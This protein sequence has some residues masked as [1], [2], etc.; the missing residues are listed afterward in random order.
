MGYVKLKQ[1]TIDKMIGEPSCAANGS[2]LCVG[3][4]KF[5]A[6]PA[7]KSH[8]IPGIRASELVSYYHSVDGIHIFIMGCM[9]VLFVV[10]S[11]AMCTATITPAD[12]L[13][14]LMESIAS[15]Q[16]GIYSAIRSSGQRSS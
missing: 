13:S 16:T 8:I 9:E 6:T 5:I 4:K 11:G 15:P 7:T 2:I 14:R 10:S 3:L 12:R 1:V